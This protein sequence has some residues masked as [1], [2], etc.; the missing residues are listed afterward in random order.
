MPQTTA[1]AAG[2][3]DWSMKYQ[4]GT[5]P[6]SQSLR[7]N[8]TAERKEWWVVSPLPAAPGRPWLLAPTIVDRRPPRRRAA[9]RAGWS[10]RC[11][12]T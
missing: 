10:R 5:R 7:E 8:F 1:A 4:D 2:L 11:R 6:T 9:R 12:S 3:F